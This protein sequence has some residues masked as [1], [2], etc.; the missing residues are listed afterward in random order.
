MTLELYKEVALTRDLPEYKLRKGD[1]GTI[2]EPLSNAKQRGYA[3]EF[4]NAVGDT[5]AVAALDERDLEPLRE[6]EVL[7]IRKLEA[8]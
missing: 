7:H 1:I 6:D 8:A 2:V 5:I 3:V 4:F